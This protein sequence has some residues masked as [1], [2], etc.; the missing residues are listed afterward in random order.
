M[1]AHA[2]VYTVPVSDGAMR[3]GTANVLE[4]H[5]TTYPVTCLGH[6]RVLYILTYSSGIL[7]LDPTDL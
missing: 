3:T 4:N 1:C 6:V 7:H 2:K 5:A